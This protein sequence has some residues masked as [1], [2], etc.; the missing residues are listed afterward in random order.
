LVLESGL[1][2]VLLTR[3]DHHPLRSTHL[4]IPRILL[5]L[6]SKVRIS[7]RKIFC[8]FKRWIDTDR[9]IFLIRTGFDMELYRYSVVLMFHAPLEA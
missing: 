3:P 8:S 2:N 7:F 5:Q 6:P 9:H 4:G 1:D